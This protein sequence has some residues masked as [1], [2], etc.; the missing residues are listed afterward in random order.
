MRMPCHCPGQSLRMITQGRKAIMRPVSIL[1]CEQL[2]LWISRL[3]VEPQ[4]ALARLEA[5]EADRYRE[6]DEATAAM[7]QQEAAAG[8]TI[9]ATVTGTRA[10][11]PPA[12]TMIVATRRITTAT[13]IS[14]RRKRD[15]RDV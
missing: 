8:R 1:A 14:A 10:S 12:F 7:A 6:D 5:A 3:A 2:P 9:A 11:L 15:A 13:A 4:A